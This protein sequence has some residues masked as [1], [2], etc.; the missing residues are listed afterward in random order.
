MADESQETKGLK[1]ILA[2]EILAKIEKGKSV[3]YDHI[4]IIGDL[5]I[6]SLN[7]PLNNGKFLI[8]SIIEIVS[9]RFEGTVNFSRSNF[10]NYINLSKTKFIEPA[11]FHGS[12]F[13][14]GVNFNGSQF[15]SSAH[16]YWSNFESD[17][18]FM[19]AE[20]GELATFHN[21]IF[22]DDTNFIKSRFKEDVTFRESEFLKLVDFSGSKFDEKGIFADSKF[23]GDAKFV[24]TRFGRFTNFRSCLFSKVLNLD[25]SFISTIFLQDAIFEMGSKVSMKNSE[26]SRLEIPWKL[27]RDKF[28]YDGSSYLALMK[29]YNNLEWYDDADECNYQYRTIRR[30][31]NLRGIQWFFDLIAWALYGYGVR[32]YHPL[33]LLVVIFFISALYYNWC[34]QAHLPGAFGLSAIILTTT[35]QVGELTGYC[36][37]VSI[38][39]RIAGWLLMSTFLVVLAKKILR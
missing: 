5:D 38:I 20:F 14:G 8:D 37:Y 19:W 34:G 31:E 11:I 4:R 25:G 21:S 24:V 29:N 17:V 6:A 10:Q 27:I 22:K 7:L 33:M 12:I 13:S 1:E 16:F 36:W 28:E 3:K 2:G 35:T 39:E 26:F 9:S 23:K 18:M 15:D 30:K 32:F